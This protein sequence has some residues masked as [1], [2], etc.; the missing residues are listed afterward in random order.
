MI[1]SLKKL[2][3]QVSAWPGISVHP[4]RFGGR[5]FCL[6]SAEVGHMHNDGAVEIPFPRAFRDALLAEGLAQQH[7]WVPESGW[8]TF[9][10][11]GEEDAAHALWLLRLSYL[12]YALK[13][14]PDPGKRFEEESERLRLSPRLKALLQRF[15]PQ[16]KD[17]VAGTGLAK[18]A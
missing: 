12:R 4:H 14:V 9:A 6:G 18:S 2:Q 5:E 10:V 1:E 17:P 15:V 11:R 3:E 16:R 8:I 13:A 7:R